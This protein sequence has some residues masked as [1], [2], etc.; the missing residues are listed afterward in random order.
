MVFKFYEYRINIKG[1]EVVRVEFMSDSFFVI[2]FGFVIEQ[3]EGILIKEFVFGFDVFWILFLMKE[4]VEMVGYIVV[5]F[6]FVIVI[7]FI[8]IIRWYVYEFLIWQDVQK[9]IDNVKEINFVFVDEFILKFMIVGEV[10]KVLVNFL[11][12]WILI[13]D[14]VIILEMFV[15][16]VFIIKDIDVLIE[17]VCQLMVRY[18]IKKYVFGNVFEVVIFFFEVEEMIMNFI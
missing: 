3:I 18:I 10:Q 12:E 11:K 6:L 5:D 7:Y 9:L 1:V 15:D 14:M 8:E 4:R 17:Y 16:W 2:N 13:R